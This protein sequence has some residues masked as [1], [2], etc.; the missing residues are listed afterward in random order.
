M[1]EAQREVNIYGYQIS[2]RGL[3]QYADKVT[4]REGVSVGVQCGCGCY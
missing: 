2:H 4:G 1:S 3:E